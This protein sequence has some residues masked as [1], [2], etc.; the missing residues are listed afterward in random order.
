[1]TI[2]A[3]V[4]ADSV[5]VRDGEPQRL[6]T[7]ELYYPRFIHA[8]FMT[9]RMFSRNASSSR[10]IPVDTIIA[11]VERDM[12]M[13]VHWGKN[14]KGM[15][16]RTEIDADEIELAKDAWREA[17]FNAIQYAK[18][19]NRMGLHKQIVNRVLE[20][21]SHIRVIVTATDWENFFELRLHHDAQPEIQ[22]LAKAMAE[23]MN[24]STPRQ[25]G[26]GGWHLPYVD[27]EAITAAS[28]HVMSAAPFTGLADHHAASLN[29][30]LAVSAARCARVSYRLHDGRIPSLEDDLRLAKSLAEDGHMSPFEHQA[31]PCHCGHRH[32]NFLGWAQ[33]RVM[34]EEREKAE[35][36]MAME[37]LKG[38][39]VNP[40]LTLMRQ[41][42]GDDIQII[43]LDEMADG[44]PK[45]H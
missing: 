4:V 3:K 33:Q 9:H 25:I 11:N 41:I 5:F 22:A 7:L 19:L 31:T 30:L 27:A 35:A 26:Y 21:W 34:M 10:A 2:T 8:E 40:F 36:Q 28:A 17:G 15:Q 16:A 43:G 18:V 14:Q 45:L 38:G 6:T 20:P 42:F 1:M 32:A 44:G 37:E 29:V 24:G 23:A 12:A 39:N 13:P